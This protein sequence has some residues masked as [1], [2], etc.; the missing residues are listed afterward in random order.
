MNESVEREAL[1]IPG[2]RHYL[3]VTHALQPI[4]YPSFIDEILHFIQLV[5]ER[6]VLLQIL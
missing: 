5:G 1:V 3:P 4:H 6:Y 2:G